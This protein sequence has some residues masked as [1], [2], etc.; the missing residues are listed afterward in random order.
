MGTERRRRTP[1]C[2][3]KSLA[4]ELRRDRRQRSG[5][6]FRAEGQRYGGAGGSEG[7]GDEPERKNAKERETED[8]LHDH[9]PPSSGT[10]DVTSR[11][12]GLGRASPGFVLKKCRTAVKEA[13][14][15]CKEM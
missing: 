3:T 8:L 6:L 7:R 10:I 2:S 12:S 1:P 9:C 5:V 15:K 13:C 11:L 4:P 14:A